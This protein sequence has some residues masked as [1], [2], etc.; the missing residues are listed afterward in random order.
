MCNLDYII[1]T[2]SEAFGQWSAPQKKRF[3]IVMG[4]GQVEK[5]VFTH[6]LTKI[7]ALPPFI[8][9]LPRYKLASFPQYFSHLLLLF[10][11]QRR[12]SIVDL[13]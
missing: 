6:F 1:R 8:F 7:M 13:S 10:L 5:R 4:G 9:T 3:S 2:A 12:V 11:L